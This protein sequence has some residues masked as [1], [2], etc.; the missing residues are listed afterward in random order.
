MSKSWQAYANQITDVSAKIDRIQAG[1]DL[2]QDDV[3]NNATPHNLQTLSDATQILP[4]TLNAQFSGVPWRD[5]SGF[6]NILNHNDLGDIDA[7][8]VQAVSVRHLAQL[9]VRVQ[10]KLAA[11]GFSFN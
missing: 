3:R 4:D 1:G 9:I 5:V 7:L 8:T 11:D 2:T 6:R 10:A